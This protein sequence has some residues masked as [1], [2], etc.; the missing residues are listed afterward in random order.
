MDGVG[1]ASSGPWNTNFNFSGRTEIDWFFRR[2]PGV[3]DEVCYTGTGSA[4][5]FAHNLT[6]VP[7]LIIHKKRSSTGFWP[8]NDPTQPW[9]Y[10]LY[11][12]QTNQA[13]LSSTMWNNTPPTASVFTVGTSLYTNDAAATYVAYLF[14]TLAGI[15]K[16]GSYTGNGT[17]LTV[18]M[19]FAA[20][21][22]FFMCKRTDSTGDWFVWDSVRGIVAGNDPHLS[23]NTTAAEVTTDDSVDPD[24]S[25]IIVNELASTHINVNT[26]TYI[27]LAFA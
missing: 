17:S 6:V 5:T 19:G 15:S 16:V 1:A 11:L 20:G 2:Y 23:L 24:N 7:E 10:Q 9:T 27:Y 18:N 14:A 13:Q 12:D 22:R 8:V 21:A 26:A 3:F 4:T 25:G